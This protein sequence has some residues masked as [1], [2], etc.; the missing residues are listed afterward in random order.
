MSG[1][2][3]YCYS[4]G[5]YC[6]SS[7]HQQVTWQGQGRPR[8]ASRLYFQRERKELLLLL[9]GRC[10]VPVS[11]YTDSYGS[12]HSTVTVQDCTVT[13]QDCTAQECGVYGR[14]SASRCV[15]LLYFQREKRASIT[16]SCHASYTAVWEHPWPRLWLPWP[17][18]G[19]SR[20]GPTT[21]CLPAR[22]V[23]SMAY[24]VCLDL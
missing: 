2:N 19:A 6:N 7:V 4:T 10:P 9:R 18:G 5:L 12:V 24:S 3:Q 17:G 11:K 23:S 20:A 22:A 21:Q 8:V 1:A 13:V 14:P 15:W 16:S